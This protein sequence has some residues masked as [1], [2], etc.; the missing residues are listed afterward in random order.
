MSDIHD[1]ER[2]LT[3]AGSRTHIDASLDLHT[4]ETVTKQGRNK[5]PAHLRLILDDEHRRPMWRR[6]DPG[7]GSVDLHGW[8]QRP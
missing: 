5:K 1:D 7:G 2:G 4:V 6:S 8:L 3:S